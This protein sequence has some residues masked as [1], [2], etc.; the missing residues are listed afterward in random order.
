[1]WKSHFHVAS[2]QLLFKMLMC[3][4]DPKI[5]ITLI[6]FGYYDLELYISQLYA[7]IINRL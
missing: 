2:Y 1:M 3:A 5:V 7:N 6:L 4:A